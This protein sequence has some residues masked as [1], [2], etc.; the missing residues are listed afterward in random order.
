MSPLMPD[1]A[2]EMITLPPM[3]LMIDLPRR[4]YAIFLSRC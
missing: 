2:A 3:I 1:F 4:H